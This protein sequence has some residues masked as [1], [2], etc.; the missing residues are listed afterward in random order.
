MFFLVENFK[1]IDRFEGNGRCICSVL[2][3]F[4]WSPTYKSG[5]RH[6]EPRTSEYRRKKKTP[7]VADLIRVS[8]LQMEQFVRGGSMEGAPFVANPSFVQAYLL[9]VSLG[10]WVRVGVQGS[11][12]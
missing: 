2:F 4:K 12:H 10:K 3:Y 8:E 7:D 1:N 9:L 11:N 5:N 6:S